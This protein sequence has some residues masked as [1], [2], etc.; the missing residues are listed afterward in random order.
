M[1]AIPISRYLVQFGKAAQ[2]SP[3][4]SSGS[5]GGGALDDSF[6]VTT[7]PEEPKEDAA[8]QIEAAYTRGAAES[9]AAAEQEFVRKLLDLRINA[10]ARTAQERATWVAD[11]GGRLAELIRAAFVELEVTLAAS[12][13][14]VIKP[15]V[16]T[17]L[18]QQ[19]IESL[20][21]I[22]SNLLS[23]DRHQ[24]MPISRPHDP[25]TA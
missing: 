16:A 6:A 12:L 2:S 10:D 8:E 15:F 3:S 4:P 19:A 1:S 21:I 20:Q 25:P 7:F 11:E 9:R 5:F 14:R 24:A 22:L 17:A 23:N 13:E 18:R